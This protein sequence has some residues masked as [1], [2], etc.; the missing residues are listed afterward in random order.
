MIGL[1]LAL[2]APAGAQALT[3]AP[4]AV[5]Q[6]A[7][8]EMGLRPGLRLGFE[9]IH[10]VA[11]EL[12]GDLSAGSTESLDYDLGLGLAGRGWLIGDGSEGLFV[13]G[14]VTIGA[15]RVSDELGPWTSLGGGF[16][17]RLVPWFGLEAST[18]PEWAAGSSMRWRSELTAQVVLPLDQLGPRPGHG[19]V[20]HRPRPI[21]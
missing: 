19:S 12:A 13:L 9:P 4:T 7:D 14:R 17:G 15:A 5:V 11:L 8:G 2:A 16:G 3:F 1:L 20:W 18:G 6:G 10:Q 21:R